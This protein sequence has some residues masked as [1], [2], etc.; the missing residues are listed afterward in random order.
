MEHRS[1]F[2]YNL[3][4]GKWKDEFDLRNT[5]PLSFNLKGQMFMTS[6]NLDHNKLRFHSL[7]VL[8]GYNIF[9]WTTCFFFFKKNIF[10]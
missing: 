4:C 6:L 10:R 1:N 9:K 3:D 7:I 2:L 8:Y 5:L